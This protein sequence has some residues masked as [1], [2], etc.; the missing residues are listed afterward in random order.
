ML[1]F[2]KIVSDSKSQSQWIHI[3]ESSIHNWKL[4]EKPAR[5]SK[6]PQNQVK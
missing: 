2:V 1:N 4:T 3:Q 6:V 5:D